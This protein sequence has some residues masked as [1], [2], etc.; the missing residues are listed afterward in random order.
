ML[1]YKIYNHPES[2]ITYSANELKK[3]VPLAGED[4][5]EDIKSLIIDWDLSFADKVIIAYKNNIL[6]GF[7]RYDI[8]KIQNKIYAAGTYVIPEFR[9]KGLAFSLW[10]KVIELEKPKIIY[11]HLESLEGFYLINKVKKKYNNI[12]YAFSI[13]ENISPAKA[14]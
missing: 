9:S 14:S 13:S 11:G 10:E 4:L 2:K 1:T 8:G 7:Y 5:T 6:L 12:T 3:I